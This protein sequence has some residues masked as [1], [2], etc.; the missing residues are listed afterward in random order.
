MQHLYFLR[1]CKTE[2]NTQNKI[3][4]KTDWKL[5]DDP[6]VEGVELIKDKRLVIFSSDLNRCKE[7]LE[8]L[9][10]KLDNCPEIYYT[11]MLRERDMGIFEGK[12]RKILQLEYPEYF[13]NQRFCYY[14]TP[15]EGES[16]KEI[17]ERTKKFIQSEV[18]R[19][20]DSREKKDILICAH[21]QILKLLYCEIKKVPIEDN[22]SKLD[23]Q[24]GMVTEIV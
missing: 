23:F 13:M 8:I 5:C 20:L 22:W 4:G 24:N 10:K 12:E 11:D 14:E 15:P 3:S 6:I 7:T 17:L 9:G 2:A 18:L 16:Y 1:H 19:T 21:N